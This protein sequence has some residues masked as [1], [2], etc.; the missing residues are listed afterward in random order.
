MTTTPTI[1]YVIL[2]RRPADPPAFEQPTV[3]VETH[4]NDVD[5]PFTHG[6]LFDDTL[7]GRKLA[8]RLITAIRAGVVFVRPTV[9]TDK[10]GQTYVEATSMVLGKRANADLRRLGY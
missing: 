5:R 9:R 8:E 6:F 10:Y 1:H 4:W 7:H 2:E 3:C